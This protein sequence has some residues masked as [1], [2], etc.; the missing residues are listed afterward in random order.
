MKTA[1]YRIPA[2]LFRTL[3]LRGAGLWL[4]SRLMVKAAFALPRMMSGSTLAATPE[5]GAVVPAWI[6]VMLVS[7][8]VFDLHRRKELALLHNLG[9]PTS[10]AVAVVTLPGVGIELL[11]V[12]LPR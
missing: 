4:L 12:M 9:I 3:L 6:L 1:D 2:K 11:L 8:A 7:L 5:S 10:L